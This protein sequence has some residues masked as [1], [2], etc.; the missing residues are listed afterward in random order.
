MAAQDLSVTHCCGE[1][2]PEVNVMV[3]KCGTAMLLLSWWPGSKEKQEEPHDE[4]YHSVT[5]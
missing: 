1:V 5:L 3:D 4:L 2:M